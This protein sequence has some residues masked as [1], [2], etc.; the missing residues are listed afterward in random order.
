MKWLLLFIFFFHF[1]ASAICQDVETDIQQQQLESAA[2]T[3]GNDIDESVLDELENYKKHPLNLNLATTEDLR[4]LNLL[5]DTEIN[6]LLIY[7]KLFG[8][9]MHI[10]ELQAV[11]GWSLL[12][13]RKLLPYV[14]VTDLPVSGILTSL[15]SGQERLLFRYGTTL[16][17]ARGFVENHYAGNRDKYGIRYRYNYKGLLRWGFSADKDAG[18]PFFRLA[19]KRGFDFYSVHLYLR[20][21]GLVESFSLGDFTVN[22]GQGLIQWQSLAFKKSASVMNI[23][24]QAAV[25]RPYTSGGEFNFFRGGGITFKKGHTAAS[26]FVSYKNIST[27]QEK[28]V[29]GSMSISAFLTSGNHRSLNEIGDRKNAKQLS[30]GAVLRF[31]HARGQLSLNTICHRFSFPLLKTDVPYN[32]YAL[33]GSSFLNS[34]LDYSYT[35]QN[36]HIFGEV[37]A[38]QRGSI[39]AVNGLLI[40]LDRKLDAAILYRRIS[41]RYQSVLGNAFTENSLPGNERGVYTG[42][43]FRPVATLSIDAYGDIFSFPWLKYR[44]NAASRGKDFLITVNFK[45]AKKIELYSRLKS[46]SKWLNMPGSAFAID[47]LVVSERKSFRVHANIKIDSRFTLQKRFELTVFREGK[48]EKEEG[49]MMFLDISY[50]PAFGKSSV[51]GRIQFFSTDS[52]DS[53]IYAYEARM[54]Y[55]FSIPSFYGQGK[56]YL[57]N[58]N[59]RVS[60]KNMGKWKMQCSAGWIQ[61]FFKND[62]SIGSGFDEIK[63]KRRS[64]ISLQVLIDKH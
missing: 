12:L 48:K 54:P 37:A 35:Y 2:E 24:R 38:D 34:S 43:S 5:T 55:L 21:R 22:I 23:K 28:D 32:L 52:Y 62:E 33:K 7:R 18:E 8:L 10:Y 44:V 41:P 59:R 58:I 63:G 16:E 3:G 60:P 30:S 46:E 27:H 17:K 20:Q 40:S 31:S 49:A 29:D 57:L 6:N 64:E 15:R 50:K 47:P 56:R 25:L 9:L 19:Q 1:P 61:T 51:H 53:R 11:P 39:A 4:Q 26:F 42:I 45:P 36:L 14:C 13:I